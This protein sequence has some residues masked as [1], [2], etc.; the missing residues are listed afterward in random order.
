[1]SN[2]SDKS[3][4]TTFHEI[5]VQVFLRF[6]DSSK[7]GQSVSLIYE[8]VWLAEFRKSEENLLK[9]SCKVVL[10]IKVAHIFLTSRQ[11][12]TIGKCA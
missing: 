12:E 2:F 7:P 10:V 1:M 5:C 9:T 11:S 3:T 4:E 8:F 6:P